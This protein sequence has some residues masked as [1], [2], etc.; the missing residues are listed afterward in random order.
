M[1]LLF[2]L[3]LLLLLLPLSLPTATF[4]TYVVDKAICLLSPAF[5]VKLATW[6]RLRDRGRTDSTTIDNNEPLRKRISNISSDR[7]REREG[8]RGSWRKRAKT[9]G[10]VKAMPNSYLAMLSSEHSIKSRVDC[11]LLHLLLLL[12]LAIFRL[13]SV[14]TT[15]S[16][17]CANFAFAT[18]KQTC[19]REGKSSGASVWESTLRQWQRLRVPRGNK[20]WFAHSFV[21]IGGW[22]HAHRTPLPTSHRPSPSPAA[23][24]EPKSPQCRRSLAFHAIFI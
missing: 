21:S 8:E 19:Q 13:P 22:C 12:L 6:D 15:Y 1:L 4:V 11:Q 23:H 18:G 5:L 7:E 9:G 2:S 10:K 20:N 24:R 16:T 14:L 3:L 17:Q